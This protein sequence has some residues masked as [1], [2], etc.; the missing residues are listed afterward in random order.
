MQKDKKKHKQR[1]QK[2]IDSLKQ[3]ET[4]QKVTAVKTKEQKIINDIEFALK[5]RRLDRIA[6][7]NA[8]AE[9]EE[10]IRQK[11]IRDIKKLREEKAMLQ[12]NAMSDI[13]LST[14]LHVL[15]KKISRTCNV[16]YMCYIYYDKHS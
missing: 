4:A 2:V 14:I 13:Y 11:E 15:H 12:V 7:E 3:E 6:I 5:Q 8:R 16:S 9:M 1:E 10:I